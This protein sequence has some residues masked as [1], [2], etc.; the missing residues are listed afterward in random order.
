MTVNVGL[1][2]GL[3]V[4][5]PLI[6][7]AGIWIGMKAIGQRRRSRRDDELL[8]PLGDMSKNSSYLRYSDSCPEYP[9]PAYYREE[10][11]NRT[12]YQPPVEIGPKT[13][14]ELG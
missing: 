12:R 1:G 4:G 8:V 9:K 11:K 10:Y 7:I 5:I 13:P 2:V 6:L 3:G 14:T